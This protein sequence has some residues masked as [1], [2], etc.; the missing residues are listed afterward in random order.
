MKIKNKDLAIYLGFK[1]NKIGDTY[2]PLELNELK[3]LE[4]NHF[5]SFGEYVDID[6]D[7]LDF[8]NNL[9][10]ITFKNFEIDDEIINKI[11]GYSKLKSLSFD[12]SLVDFEKISQLK[13]DYLSIT[14]NALVRTD[15]FK[16]NMYKGLIITDSDLI[17][18]KN[19]EH[20]TDLEFLHIS[21]SNVI[22]YELLEKLKKISILEFD[23]TNISDISFLLELPNIK[24]VSLD[25]ELYIKNIDI[26][27]ELKKRNVTFF[28]RGYL[29]IVDYEDIKMS[30]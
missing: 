26:I 15:Y 17:D 2:T 12:H 28:E 27:K 7:I 20:M 4:L 14:N 25:K 11:K 3:D 22:N 6:L 24:K 9:E 5:N 1:L 8:T 23:E 16:N 30:K 21:N 19:I 10:S 29:P 18:I 13:I